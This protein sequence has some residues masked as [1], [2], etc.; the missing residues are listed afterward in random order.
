MTPEG[1]QAGWAA[2]AVAEREK[3]RLVSAQPTRE[4]LDT[5]LLLTVTAWRLLVVACA[6]VGFGSA[7]SVIDDPMPA[8]SQQASLLAGCV[9]SGLLLY[10]L[11]TRG[12]RHE[13]RSPWLRGAVTIVLLLVGGA[14]MTLLSGNLDARWSLFEHFLTPLIV[15]VDWVAVGS[16]QARARWWHPLTWLGLPL[17]Y[18][19]FY[20]SGGYDMYGFIDPGDGNFTTMVVTL[21]LVLLAAGYALVGVGRLRATLAR[22]RGDRL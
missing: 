13:P 5:G 14:F 12:R 8:L 4:R 20:Y 3:L 15:L 1:S 10:P 21:G 19:V 16:N 11:A 9:Y 22:A 6:F 7:V 18:L 2:A 17:A